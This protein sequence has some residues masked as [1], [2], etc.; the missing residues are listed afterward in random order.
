VLGLQRIVG[1]SSASPG[2]LPFVVAIFRDG[3][4]HCGGTI[5]SSLWVN[6]EKKN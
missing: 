1:G 4:F 3:K 2:A 6:Q 5:Y